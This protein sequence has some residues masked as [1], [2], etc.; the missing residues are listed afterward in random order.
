MSVDRTGRETA[1]ELGAGRM[2]SG[3]GDLFTVETH[4]IAPV[5]LENRYGSVHRMFTMWF[6]GTLVVSGV[7][8]GTLVVSDFIGLGFWLGALAIVVGTMIGA[9]PAAYMAT[10]GPKTGVGQLPLARLPFGKSVAIP[11]LIMWI[12]TIAWDGINTI[13]GAQA[14]ETLIGMPFW[15]GAVMVL[16]VTGLIGMFGY[17][18]IHFFQRWMTFVLGGMFVLMTIKLASYGDFST[19]PTAQGMD[20][21]GGFL[22]MVTLSISYIVLYGAYASDYSRYMKPTTSSR[23]IFW[24]VFAALVI[25]ACWMQLLGAAI[26]GV[27][28]DQT[29]AGI[30]EMMGGGVLG[31]VALLA[32]A[33]GAAAANAVNDYTGSLSLQTAGVRIIR[34]VIAVIVAVLALVITLWL[35]SGDLATKMSNILVLISYWT[36]PFLAI[37]IVDWRLRR[38][39]VDVSRLTDWGSL[40]NGGPALIALALG[41]LSALPF[42][43]T[44]LLVGPVAKALHGGDIA[45]YVSFVVAAVVYVALARR[46]V[47]PSAASSTARVSD[48]DAAAEK[49][50]V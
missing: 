7:F 3:E 17:E 29:S 44:E 12:T 5:P 18:V 26:A 1:P 10:W 13:F 8:L 15:L 21:V 14:L 25:G 33:T 42:M 38:G 6:P 37:V 43:N 22:L 11:G 30:R 32:I 36:P 9:L 16:G 41:F 28:T 48:D 19:G 50:A 24:M 39:R 31:A 23:G 27:A 49:V 4:G 45:Y 35:N 34:P 2:P 20:R 40:S 46:K 47:G